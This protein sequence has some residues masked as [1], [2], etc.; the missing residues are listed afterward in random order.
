MHTPGWILSL[1]CS[2]L[3]GRS[4]LLS[5]NGSTSSERPLPGGFGAGT[6]LGGMLFIVKFNGAC[7][8]PPIPRP[9]TGNTGRQFKYIDDSC[10]VASVNLKLSLEPDPQSRPRPFTYFERTQM[11][12]KPSENIL[13]Q[14]LLKFEEFTIQ[15][16]LVINSSK[17]FIMYFSRSKKYAF[18][19]EFSIGNAQVLEVK[20]VHRIL[21]IQV[22]DDLR[23]QSQV[24][25]MV[26]RATK[27]TWVLR[28]MRALGVDQATLVAYWKAEGRVHLEL[29]CP[30]WHSGLTSQQSRDLD[31]AQRVAMAAI[32]GRWEPSHTRQLHDLGLEQL[33]ARRTQL[34]ATFGRRTATDS[35]H[36][37]IFPR[38]G[39]PERPG[40]A[41]RP[42][43]EPFCR[44]GSHFNSAVPYL[45]RQLNGN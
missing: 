39:A 38:S 9:I 45:T 36:M 12:L 15:N 33:A 17:C 28:R 3:S 24:E 26:K 43:T 44:T 7:I 22:Q 5:H 13:Q 34:C 18:P 8:R 25:V 37:D 16:K 31:R 42:Y 4:L 27:T 41:A 6:W 14:Q 40:K 30:V 23:W 35:R 10:Q 29:A 19:L 20:K 1:V 32:T 2:Y 21:G 11:R